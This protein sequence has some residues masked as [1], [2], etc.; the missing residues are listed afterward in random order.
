MNKS[1]LF[2]NLAIVIQI[3]AF[4]VA[5]LI[6]LKYQ[7]GQLKI[8]LLVRKWQKTP[9]ISN[10]L[11]KYRASD[12]I[13]SENNKILPHYPTMELLRLNDMKY[14]TNDDDLMLAIM[15]YY[16][17]YIDKLLRLRNESE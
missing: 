2:N 7:Y 9:E 6:F 13:D 15:N 17:A 1:A 5:V 14:N 11:N 3:V 4:A 10:L 12:F 8:F 16:I